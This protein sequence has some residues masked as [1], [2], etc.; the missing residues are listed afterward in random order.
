MGTVPLCALQGRNSPLC[1]WWH[2]LCCSQKW[3]EHL[4]LRVACIFTY[5]DEGEEQAARRLLLV[6]LPFAKDQ[7]WRERSVL[8][9]SVLEGNRMNRLA[10]ILTI[11]CM[12][13]I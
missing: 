3:R 10:S 13:I 12:T 7:F 5:T 6:L 8:E 9:S 1:S 4:T 11:T 2:L